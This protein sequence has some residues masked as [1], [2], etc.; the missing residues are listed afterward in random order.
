MDRGHFY[1]TDRFEKFKDIAEEYAFVFKEFGIEINSKSNETYKGFK[2]K[3][4]SYI[5]HRNLN[6]QQQCSIK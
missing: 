4:I 6:R 1:P 3:M 5:R 2:Y